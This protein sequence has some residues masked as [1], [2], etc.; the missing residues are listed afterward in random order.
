LSRGERPSHGERTAEERERDRAERERRRAERAG[1]TPPAVPDAPRAPQEPARV[2]A[3]PIAPTDGEH[4]PAGAAAGVADVPAASDA[5]EVPGEHGVSAAWPPGE[6]EP[7]A[8]AP[9][10]EVPAAGDREAPAPEV[11]AAEDRAA[12][13]PMEPAAGDWEAPAEPAAEAGDAPTPEEHTPEEPAPEEPAPGMGEE[14]AARP[15]AETPVPAEPPAERPIRVRDLAAAEAA[16]ESRSV[17]AEEERP[18]LPPPPPLALGGGRSGSRTPPSRREQRPGRARLGALVALV[19]AAIAVAVVLYLLLHHGAG[20]KTPPA[21]AV[22]KVLIPEGKTRLQ[23]EQIAARAGLRG[24]YRLASRSSPLLSPTQYGAP[25]ST[26]DLE[27]FLFPAT[28]D[29][30]AHAPVSRL[31]AEQLEAFKENFG[32]EM[33]AAAHALH[34]TPYQMLIVASMVERE[35]LLSA[36]RPKVA[37]VIYNRLAKGIPLGIDAT[38]YYAIEL[39]RNIPTYTAELTESELHM[40]SA[41]NTRTRVGL[42]PTPISNP[43]VAS[44][45]AAAHP[46]R[47]HYLYYVAGADG[48]GDL[49]FAETSATWEADAAAYEAAVKRNGGHPPTCKK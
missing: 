14:P 18:R 33:V 9:A 45:E 39:Q 41:Y 32:A 47:A 34:V 26:K 48:C 15:R 36:D 35:A 28:Y 27:G 23:I 49:V 8:P 2:R 20:K 11:P 4:A 29:E 31:V 5:S 1:R 21:R 30:Y 40:N 38:L 37:A 12:P 7:G 24:S 22:V 3:E 13:A 6:P 10:P 17:E 19:A 42:P 46:A 16:R 25:S 43:G 44:M